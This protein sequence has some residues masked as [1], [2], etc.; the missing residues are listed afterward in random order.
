M[1]F[2]WLPFWP[3]ERLYK[4]KIGTL[5]NSRPLVLVTACDGLQ[6][7]SAVNSTA[8]SK[9]IQPGMLLT[10][11]RVIIPG[12]VVHLAN[13]DASLEALGKLA[14]W[15]RRYSPIVA[16]DG[17]D[18]IQ[19]DIT[20]CAHLF[21]G[22]TALLADLLSR[23]EK[24][25]LSSRAAIAS[26]IGA[27]WAIAHYSETISNVISLDDTAQQISE[28]PVKGLRLPENIILSLNRVGLRSIGDLY[29]VPREALVSRFG[30]IVNRRLDQALGFKDEPVLR[31]PLD[32]DFCV[33]MAFPEPISCITDINQ[34]IRSLMNQLCRDLEYR[35]Y[36][37]ERFE[38][39]L[40]FS[41]GKVRQ[42]S[43]DCSR[44]SRN[45]EH[46]TRLVNDHLSVL[47]SDF[48][49]DLIVLLVLVGQPLESVQED[50][51][52]FDKSI[53][54]SSLN[55]SDFSLLADQG[56]INLVDRIGNRLGSKNIVRFS[57]RQ[58]YIPEHAVVA[59]AAL[60][61]FNLVNLVNN[62]IP[63]PI[64]LLPFP[65]LIKVLAE[66]P[67]S[68]PAIFYWRNITHRVCWA[69]KPERIAPEWWKESRI[70]NS[71]LA[72]DTRDY[73]QVEDG[74][75]RRFWL[76]RKAIYGTANVEPCWY[77]HGFFA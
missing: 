21:G 44:P 36:G 11:V 48:G 16:V 68:P 59:V 54:G 69:G 77:M 31:K 38:L 51:C 22:E 67:D 33:K 58:S 14:D 46:L 62:K 18:G 52:V 27:A 12:L 9:G 74:S 60:E 17:D 8:A 37:V 28:L 24:F 1:L 39:A 50:F 2:L 61:E 45:P 30:N 10:D 49:I 53:R 64:L 6:R 65:E 13:P 32:T 47:E 42:I 7:I 23:L 19:I 75:G 29:G 15:C 63:R 26:S 73:Y 41:E 35:E 20:G 3:L 4:P 66:V 71:N 56:L 70:K 72:N 5:T 25:G 76:F 40:H 55:H 57:S 34:A 43:I